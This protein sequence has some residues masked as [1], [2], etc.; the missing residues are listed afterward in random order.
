MSNVE[1]S[2]RWV[3]CAESEPFLIINTR[4]PCLR[5]NT[6]LT[7][8]CMQTYR[9]M[10]LKLGPEELKKDPGQFLEERF[11]FVQ[12]ILELCSVSRMR[13]CKEPVKRKRP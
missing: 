1:G 12:A 2:S 6:I 4:L 11:L 5:R 3:V 10:Q 7:L 13:I 9:Y 8:A